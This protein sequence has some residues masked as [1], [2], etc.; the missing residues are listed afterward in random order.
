M[1]GGPLYHD[2]LGS[3][4]LRTTLSPVRPE[5]GRKARFRGW[6]P[7][8]VRKAETCCW[9][10]SKRGLDQESVSS[11]LTATMMRCTPMLRTRRACSFV[12]PFSPDSKP[13]VL[14]SMTRTAKSA[15]LAPAIMLGMKSRW[16]GASRIVNAVLSVSN[17]FMP[18]SIVTPWLRSSV[19]WSSTHASAN[20]DF[21][22]LS[23]SLR[24]LSS[25]LWSTIFRS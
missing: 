18:M 20:E 22:M 19:P 17:L 2:A 14:A 5:Q 10:S 21:P 3:A 8:A 7:A 1:S 12:C 25:V 11:L 9:I 6:K 13:P 16:P 24:Y 23:A 15:W 4:T